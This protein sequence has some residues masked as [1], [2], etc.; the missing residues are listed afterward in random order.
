MFLILTESFLKRELKPLAKY[1]NIEDIKK[2]TKKISAS[3]IRLSN[4]GYKGGELMKLRITSRTVG[5]IIVYVYKQKDLVVPVVLRL[6]KDKIIGENL[7]LNNVKAKSII[8]NMMDRIMND[9]NNGN[10]KKETI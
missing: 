2:T 8:L 7:A 4:L 10:Y 3:S 9:I 6:K 1:Y 5:R